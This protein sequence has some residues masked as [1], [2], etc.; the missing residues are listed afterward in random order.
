MQNFMYNDAFVL[1]KK[2]RHQKVETD[3]FIGMHR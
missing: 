3:I 1:K 2:K